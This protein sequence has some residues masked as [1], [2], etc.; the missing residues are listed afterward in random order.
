MTKA[1]LISFALTALLS[2]MQAVLIYDMNHGFALSRA[3]GL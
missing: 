3:L 2:A 1:V